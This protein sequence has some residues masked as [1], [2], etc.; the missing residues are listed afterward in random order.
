M[1]LTHSLLAPG[2]LLQ[3]I[4]ANAREARLAQNLSR[5]SLALMTG[6]SES[7]IKRFEST[8]QITLDALVLI[9][10]ALG[11]TRQLAELFKHERPISLEEI[12]QTGRTRGRQ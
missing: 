10:T 7:T 11:A 2:E 12:K 4:G 8:G 9:A 1:A 5:K 6:V 3:K